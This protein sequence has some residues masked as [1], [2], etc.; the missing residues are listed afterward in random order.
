MLNIL[1]YTSTEPQKA[2]IHQAKQLGIQLGKMYRLFGS[3]SQL[4]TENKSLL[5][6]TI[7]KPM[8][9]YGDQL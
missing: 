2:R 7:L 4:L 6:K 9:A 3:K 1:D 5:Y 8:W